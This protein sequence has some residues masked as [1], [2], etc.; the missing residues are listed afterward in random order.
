ME[1][2]RRAV[3]RAKN[4]GAPGGGKPSAPAIAAGQTQKGTVNSAQ[5]RRRIDG[6]ESEV[7]LNNR[8][9]R[10]HRIISHMRGEP[11]SRSFDMLRT[12]IVQAMD[13]KD[14]RVI[15]ITSPSPSCGKTVTALNLAISISRQPD[16]AVLVVDLDLEKPKIASCLGLK[17]RQGVLGVLKGESSLSGAIVSARADNQRFMVLPTASTI[18][19]SDLVASAEMATMFEEL[20]RDYHT[21]IVDLPPILTGDEVIAILPKI[22]CV[23]LV[24]AVGKSTVAEIEECNKHLQATEVVRVVLNKSADASVGYY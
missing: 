6:Q 15:G 12:Q 17:D 5:R 7:A 3:E 8:W 16:R 20:R 11:A 21:I 24:V 2:I 18:D 14:W 4:E 1:S 19:S 22:D 13:Q 9:L 10:S 23:L